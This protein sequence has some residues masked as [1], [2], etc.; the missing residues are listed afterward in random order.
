MSSPALFARNPLRSCPVVLRISPKGYLPNGL[1]VPCCRVSQLLAAREAAGKP[2]FLPANRHDEPEMME[3]LE[4]G[5]SMGIRGRS[6]VPFLKRRWMGSLKRM[7]FH[8]FIA[9]NLRHRFNNDASKIAAETSKPLIFNTIESR[10]GTPQ[11]ETYYD[12]KAHYKTGFSNLSTAST[13]HIHQSRGILVGCSPIQRIQYS[14]IAPTTSNP[15][16]IASEKCL[17]WRTPQPRQAYGT[18]LAPISHKVRWLVVELAVLHILRLSHL[19]VHP[20]QLIYGNVRGIVEH[21]PIGP[22][23]VLCKGVDSSKPQRLRWARAWRADNYGERKRTYSGAQFRAVD[24]DT[25]FKTPTSPRKKLKINAQDFDPK[26]GLERAEDQDRKESHLVQLWHENRK[27]TLMMIGL[28]S[29][30]QR[31]ERITNLECGR[32]V[33][34]VLAIEPRGILAYIGCDHQ[35]F[36]EESRI[37]AEGCQL[38]P[39]TQRGRTQGNEID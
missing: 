17:Q 4:L 6:W 8:A 1:K 38:E 25:K 28:K 39:E 10:D 7:T 3:Y 32:S 13:K 16:D 12:D 9:N 37:G 33:Y 19:E 31:W 21:F 36:I 23:G 24:S 11:K 5:V 14:M 27:K 30:Q 29:H 22:P 26:S 15:P 2:Y 34:K 35:S 18:C 20:I